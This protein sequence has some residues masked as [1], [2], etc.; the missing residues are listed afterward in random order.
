[1]TQ[2]PGNRLISRFSDATGP[3]FLWRPNIFVAFR[4]EHTDD[5]V[6]LNFAVVRSIEGRI[7]PFCF[8]G[9]S[10]GVNQ[11]TAVF[12]GHEA[13]LRGVSLFFVWRTFSGSV[14]MT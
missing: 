10:D 9:E 12:R 5:V 8:R 6:Y 3:F 7:A 13:E 1:V 14:D 2:Q 4:G 11:G